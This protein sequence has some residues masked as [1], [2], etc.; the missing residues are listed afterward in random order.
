MVVATSPV[1]EEFLHRA[2]IR[3]AF[4]QVRGETVAERMWTHSLR[5]P[6]RQGR[7]LDRALQRLFVPV[8]AS[9]QAAAGIERVAP[10]GEHP[11]PR[12]LESGPGVLCPQGMRQVHRR[13]LFAGGGPLRSVVALPEDIEPFEVGT[14]RFHG[15]LGQ[16]RV[17]VPAA[18]ACA[19]GNHPPLQ[20]DITH[21]QA[22]TFH[23]P[24]P[25]AVEQGGGQPRGAVELGQQGGDFLAVEDDGYPGG[26]FDPLQSVEFAQGPLE[27]LG[28][29]EDQGVEGLVVGGSS[30][31]VGDG[32]ILQEGDDLA[33][34]QAGGMTLAVKEN[35][36]ARP[37]Q[38]SLFGAQTHALVAQAVA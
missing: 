2:D 1:A 10:G 38:V 29:K 9:A 26:A 13:Q 17:P 36:P 19:H 23:E 33:F 30:D 22:Q 3:A 27:Y 12:P 34:G 15:L 31:L 32:Q 14:Q 18:L 28:V 35:E 6:R 24:Q 5:Q 37:T 8:V 7:F 25:R 20:V 11:L 4:Q 21:P 16:R